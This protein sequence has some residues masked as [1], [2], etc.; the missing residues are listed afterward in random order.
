MFQIP[1]AT[2]GI[3]LEYVVDLKGNAKNFA[4]E[5]CEGVIKKK[6]EM[7]ET[8]EEDKIFKCAYKR[9]RSILQYLH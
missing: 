2:F 4:I 6:E 7:P 3:F 1:A 9:A 5:I 8:Q